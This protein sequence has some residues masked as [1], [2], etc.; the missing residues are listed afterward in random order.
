MFACC[1]TSMHAANLPA[2]VG[3]R[4]DALKASGVIGPVSV[5]QCLS[6]SCQLITVQPCVFSQASSH[7]AT[8][9]DTSPKGAVVRSAFLSLIAAGP[10]AS[11]LA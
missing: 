9:A 3:G 8:V 5:W 10:A 2:A 1:L 6:A 4:S 11:V 7:V